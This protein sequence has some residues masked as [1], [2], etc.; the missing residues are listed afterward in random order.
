MVP[1]PFPGPGPL[2]MAAASSSQPWGTSPA[3]PWLQAAANGSIP[4][5][6]P[7]GVPPMLFPSQPMPPPAVPAEWGDPAWYEWKA[8]EGKVRCL[9]CYKYADENHISSE[10][11]CKRSKYPGSYISGYQGPSGEPPEV[12]FD[13]PPPPPP[14]FLFTGAARP[15]PPPPP[16]V[17]TQPSLLALP[18][19]SGRDPTPPPAQPLAQP[20]AATPSI[21]SGQPPP[22]PSTN[23]W[24]IMC[25]LCLW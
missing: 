2:P 12:R 23:G 3:S 4:V 19:P 25:G 6:P 15:P 20:L 18:A 24:D 16:A 9:L 13:G 1:P 17:S 5:H 21:S 10:M 22:D 14:A 11:H 8:K 7:V